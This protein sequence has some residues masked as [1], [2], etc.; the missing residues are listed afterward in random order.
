M[1]IR[2]RDH[3][4]IWMDSFH[5][6]VRGSTVRRHVVGGRLGLRRRTRDDGASLLA[7]RAGREHAPIQ[8]RVSDDRRDLDHHPDQHD[9]EQIE[10]DFPGTKTHEAFFKTIVH[11]CSKIAPA[12]APHVT[13]MAI[14]VE[15]AMRSLGSGL[16]FS[17]GS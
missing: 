4:K 12:L 10:D 11:G 14:V 17:W 13:G 1:S 16:V 6:T 5:P 2:I 15:R 9:H 7:Y 8:D 3:A